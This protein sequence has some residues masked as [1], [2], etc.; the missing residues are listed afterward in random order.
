MVNRI[1]QYHFGRGIVRSPNNFGLQGDKPTHP[2]LLDWLAAELLRQGW[3]LKPLHR[4]I[5]ASNAYRMSSREDPEALKKDPVNDLFWRFDMRRLGAEEIRDSILAVTGTLNLK[6]Y[7]PGVY[8]A[9]P[10]EVMAG[11]S[12]PGKGW[13]Q[14]SPEEQAR[15]SVYVHVKRSLL[16]PILESF[17]VAETD[18]P[19]PVRFATTQPTQALAMLNGAFLNQQA[20]LL[21]A[22]LRGEGGRGVRPRRPAPARDRRPRPPAS[23]A[24]AP[25]G[26]LPPARRRRD[27]ARRRPDRRPRKA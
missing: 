21:A 14:S 22:R 2:E 18:R 12:Q 11:Q 4:L 10:A 15:R 7:G 26:D 27:P 17:D 25:P 19:S 8:P 3:R 23:C 13:G 6:M 1:W 24:G 16:V 20:E 5:M 9:I